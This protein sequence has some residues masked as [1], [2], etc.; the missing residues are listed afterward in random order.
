MRHRQRRARITDGDAMSR[1]DRFEDRKRL[2]DMLAK[3][4]HASAH[5]AAPLPLSRSRYRNV[6][7]DRLIAYLDRKYRGRGLGPYRWT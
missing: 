3:R 6:V 5:D 2:G 7:E 1:V 4:G